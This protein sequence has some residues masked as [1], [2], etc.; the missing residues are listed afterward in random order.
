MNRE[1]QKYIFFSEFKN[2]TKNINILCHRRAKYLFFSI[3]NMPQK[4]SSVI[5]V[6]A[7]TPC[8]VFLYFYKLHELVN[9][10][11]AIILTSVVKLLVLDPEVA[12]SNTNVH[13][14]Y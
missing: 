9:K 12:G 7:D 10:A 1:S 13:N 11:L 2:V 14:M 3:P 6:R 5:L 8:I 4:S